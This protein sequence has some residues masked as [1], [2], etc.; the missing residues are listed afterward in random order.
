MAKKL[1]AAVIGCGAIAQHCHLKG[2]ASHPQ[3]S[4]TA[5]ADVERAR[6]EEAK[7]LFKVKNVYLH[8]E[9]MLEKEA[10][11][12][13]SVCTPNYL[14][15]D[16]VIRAAERG[17]HILCEKPMALTLQDG[18]RMIEAVR[19]NG[20]RM[21]LGFTHRFL[22]GNQLAKQL[23]DEGGI[24]DA[25]MI[26]VR[27]AHE[28]PEP[29][30]A[31]SDWFTVPQKA[32]GGACLDMGVHAFDLCQ[33]YLGPIRTVQANIK[34]IVKDIQVDDNAVLLFEFESGG[35]GYV[36]AG[37]TS[38]PGFIG[39]EIYGTD[40]TL[41]VDYTRGLHLIRGSSSAAEAAKSGESEKLDVEVTAGGWDVEIE[42]FVDCIRNKKPFLAGPADGLSALRIALAGYESSKTGKKV[43]LE[44]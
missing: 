39:C 6:L 14:H 13:V 31:M 33:Y 38:K 4:L 21:M 5:A 3:V 17:C 34:T 32:G 11:D 7:S 28:G 42:H 15:A 12:L 41:L 30:W 8:Y 22:A 9:E 16:C 2:Y 40:G 1:K 26:R 37:W 19:N 43:V 44:E 24:G 10:L 18:E 27:F 29:D 20:V 25:F 35:L 36:E 23:L